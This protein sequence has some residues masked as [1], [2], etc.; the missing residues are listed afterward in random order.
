MDQLPSISD[1]YEGKECSG[2][3]VAAFIGDLPDTSENTLRSS[4]RQLEQRLLSYLETTTGTA[5]LDLLEVAI[6]ELLRT[7][8]DTPWKALTPET[9]GIAGAG[10]LLPDSSLVIPR[11]MAKDLVASQQPGTLEQYLVGV[12]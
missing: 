4:V 1:I 12:V 11:E 9:A 8:W 6:G 2:D 7:F 10:I 3:D 5:N